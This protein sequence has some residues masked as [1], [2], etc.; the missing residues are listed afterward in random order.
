LVAAT[1]TGQANIFPKFGYAINNG[2]R[3]RLDQQGY[4]WISNAQLYLPSVA[5]HAIVL[6]GSYQKEDADNVLFSNRFA[7]ARGYAESD[8]VK[9]WK[10][11]GK[12]SHAYRLS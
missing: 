9:M 4:Q 3:H 7:N 2:Y 8:S 6:S 5:N 11:G 10:A 12:L 1:T